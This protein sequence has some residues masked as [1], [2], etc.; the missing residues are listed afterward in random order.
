M[1]NYDFFCEECDFEWE[2]FSK[3]ADLPNVECPECG[4]PGKVAIKSR[5]N[6]I[7]DI[8]EQFDYGLGKRIRSRNHKRETLKRINGNREHPL[9]EAG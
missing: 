2:D 5:P 7:F 6:V 1:P 9:E 8:E 4:G 3:V